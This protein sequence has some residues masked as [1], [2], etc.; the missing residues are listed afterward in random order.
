MR[1][2][3]RRRGHPLGGGILLRRTP[4]REPQVERVLITGGAG[5]IGSN[6]AERVLADGGEVVIL[7][8]FDPF[9]DVRTKRR[10]LEAIRGKGGPR[11]RIV[12]GDIRD[13]A[14][15]RDA[16]AGCSVV[17]H[18]AALAGVRPSIQEPARY[19]DVN[20]TGT[21]ILLDEIRS[22]D[23]RF[24]FGSSSSVYGGRTTMPFR[25]TDPVDAPV[26]L[27]TGKGGC[28]G[29]FARSA[30]RALTPSSERTSSSRAVPGTRRRDHAPE[31]SLPAIG[32]RSRLARYWAASRRT[33]SSSMNFSSPGV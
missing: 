14:A 33:T 31:D 30:A 29:S 2:T 22:K 24:V 15:C 23:V 32:R 4:N 10:N 6:L 9:Y 25:E 3:A 18:L 5:F 1:E 21:Q 13:R 8:N 20:V 12:E 28:E 19:M 7:D 16:L 27:S 17:V 26:S 11:V